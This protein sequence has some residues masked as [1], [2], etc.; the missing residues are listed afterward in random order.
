MTVSWVSKHQTP[1]STFKGKCQI[2]AC[3]QFSVG[4]C[5]SPPGTYLCDAGNYISMS[6]VL[7]GIKNC[8]DG[9]DEGKD[10]DK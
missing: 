10:N 2:C 7:D 6:A 8:V 3:I 9:D 5:A 4:E 1:T